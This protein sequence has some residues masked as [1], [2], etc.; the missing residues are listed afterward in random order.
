[1]HPL[2]S[3]V[4][5]RIA[6]LDAF[7]ANPEA[8]PPDRELAQTEDGIGAGEGKTVVG[9]DRLR[10]A[11]VLKSPFKHGKCVDRFG[12]RQSIATDQVTTGEVGDGAYRYRSARRR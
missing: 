5:L 11:K 4:L 8:Q 6:W 3:A 7:D 12:R 2:V 9:A 1:M 10:Q